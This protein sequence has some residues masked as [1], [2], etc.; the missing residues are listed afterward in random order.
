[1]FAGGKIWSMGWSDFLMNI[2]LRVPWEQVF[3]SARDPAKKLK[4]LKEVMD[5]SLIHI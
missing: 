5:L 3:I 4:E 2:A 1:M